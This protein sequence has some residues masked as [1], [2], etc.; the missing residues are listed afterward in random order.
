MGNPNSQQGCKDNQLLIMEKPQ[1]LRK[2]RKTRKASFKPS[3]GGFVIV[4][5]V[6]ELLQTTLDAYKD[7]TSLTVIPKK[8]QKYLN[9]KEE[10][11]KLAINQ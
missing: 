6:H 1:K 3:M 4:D 10:K 5:K 11:V 2:Q 8:I 9:Q 7:I